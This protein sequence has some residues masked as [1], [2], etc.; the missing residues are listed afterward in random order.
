MVQDESLKVSVR[1]MKKIVIMILIDGLRYDY[2]N[3]EVSP[4]LSSLRDSGMSGIVRETFAFQLRPAF[5]AGLYPETCDIGHLFWYDPRDSPF[6]FTRKLPMPGEIFQ[7]E[8]STNLL[9]DFL[10][11]EAKSLERSKGYSASAHYADT[12]Q[13]PY[14]LL[15]YF[16]FPEKYL[17]W[18]PKSLPYPTLFD[19]LRQHRLKWLHVGYPTEDQRTG[20]ISNQFKR[21]IN[22]ECSFV[23]LHFGELDWVGHSEGPSS[24]E[25]KRVL[26]NIDSAVEEIFGILERSFGRVRALIFGD[27]GMV[28][29]QKTVDIKKE[30]EEI[31]FRVPKDYIYFLDST[32][33]RFWF[34]SRQA[35]KR[36][37]E[38]LSNLSNGRILSK[39]D[40]ERLRIRYK[41][42]RFGDLYFIVE[43][44]TL[45]CPNFFQGSLMVKGMHGYL[46]EVAGNWATL[47]ITGT[48]EKRRLSD[49]V[50]M[51]D[52][53]PTTL[54]LLELPI[55]R[56]C[57]GRSFIT[58]SQSGSNCPDD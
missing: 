44:N 29:V 5:F 42:N 56:S 12:A 43:D 21:R 27:H 45:V 13:I 51:V 19:I 17:I 50:E 2:V 20:I 3:E 46:P 28:E 30:L 22:D 49:C 16:G 34:K 32:Q 57:E 7:D 24:A 10:A 6:K 36:V 58:N 38:T 31:D 14:E 54:D 55:P 41:H 1:I 39:E 26:R 47:I 9:R 4:F 8:D 33:A 11:E 52:L 15:Q 18:E 53:F 48:K 37:K 23:F 40:Y 35:E 25:R